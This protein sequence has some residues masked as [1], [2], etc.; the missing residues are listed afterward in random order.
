MK[1]ALVALLLLAIALP[2]AAQRFY[3]DNGQYEGRFDGERW[4]SSTG[5]F[6][7]RISGDRMYLSNGTF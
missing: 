1:R 2:A 4:Y 5:E 7:L 6:V 3:A